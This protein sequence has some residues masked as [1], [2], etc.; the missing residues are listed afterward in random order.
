MGNKRTFTRE[1]LFTH[2]SI[3]VMVVTISAMSGYSSGMKTSKRHYVSLPDGRYRATY[4][5]IELLIDIEFA[6]VPS[7]HIIKPYKII[8]S[9][10]IKYYLSNFQILSILG[11]KSIQIV[12]SFLSLE[13]YQIVRSYEIISCYKIKVACQL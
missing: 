12:E 2:T 7:Y 8:K 9:Y 5:Q 13:S 6:S 11:M 10:Q 3:L 1:K 4:I